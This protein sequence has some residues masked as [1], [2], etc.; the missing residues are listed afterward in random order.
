MDSLR[1]AFITGV[2][3]DIHLLW[4]AE[5]IS[6]PVTQSV[7]AVKA[8]AAT[9]SGASLKRDIIW[10]WRII[11]ISRVAL[12]GRVGTPIQSLG[13]IKLEEKVKCLCGCCCRWIRNGY[14]MRRTRLDI[15][16]ELACRIQRTSNAVNQNGRVFPPYGYRFLSSDRRG[17]MG[18]A[19]IC[20]QRRRRSVVDDHYSRRAGCLRWLRR[21]GLR[22]WRGRLLLWLGRL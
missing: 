2:R 11:Q 8:R 12:A 19:F 22:L 1:Q 10:R 4:R 13:Q 17:Y 16:G 18:H 5:P 9:W 14:G 7:G 21:R 20:R 6:D 3:L 15:N